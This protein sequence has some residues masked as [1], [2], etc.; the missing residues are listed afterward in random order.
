MN[1]VQFQKGL[2]MVEFLD[3][4]GREE[5]CEQGKRSAN[6]SPHALA[7]P[8]ASCYAETASVQAG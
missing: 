2:S 8:D 7:G 6:P 1:A 5:Q 3:H 4:Y